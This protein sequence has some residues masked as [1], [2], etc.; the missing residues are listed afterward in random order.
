VT[1]LTTSNPFHSKKKKGIEAWKIE[2]T[3]LGICIVG[4]KLPDSCKNSLIKVLG[5]DGPG[6]EGCGQRE[7]ETLRDEYRLSMSAPCPRGERP[8]NKALCRYALIKI[9]WFSP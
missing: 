3:R 6:N 2:V 5:R 9:T 8:L 1:E 4:G 7:R